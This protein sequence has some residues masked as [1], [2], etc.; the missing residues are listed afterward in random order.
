MHNSF[1]IALST[2][3]MALTIPAEDKDEVFNLT[4]PVWAAAA[5]TNDVQSWEKE[6][7]LF[8]KDEKTDMTNG[9]W[10]FMRENSIGVE[11][12]K[13]R[14]LE[15]VKEHVAAFVKT[16]SQI[17]SRLDLSHDSRLF[18]EA[19][20]Y[21]VSGNLMWGIS[22]PRYHSNQ[23]LDELMVA[24]MKYGWP[25]HR[26]VNT[27]CN[28]V[29]HR[30]TKRTHRDANGVNG[31]KRVNGTNGINGKATKDTNGVKTKRH[32]TEACSR[33]LIKDSHLVLNVE[34]NPLSSAV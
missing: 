29:G 24:R 4:R 28:D 32:K 30:G 16:L 15:K 18:V 3:A 21:M 9:V 13:H 5:L 11:E 12:A 20:Q 25:N 10:I 34:L 8:Q 17:H 27:T 14:I 1:L 7:R 2:F 33:D 26:E 6:D 31:I 19:M 23:S 22:T